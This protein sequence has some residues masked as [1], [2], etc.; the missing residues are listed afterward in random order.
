[1]VERLSRLCRRVRRD[2]DLWRRLVLL[3]L[4]RG[5][6]GELDARL[7]GGLQLEEVQVEG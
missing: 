5:Q 2:R 1:M 3:P 6:R 7:G 4:E